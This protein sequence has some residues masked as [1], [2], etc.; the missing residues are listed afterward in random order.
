MTRRDIMTSESTL[1]GLAAFGWLM[2]IAACVAEFRMLRADMKE[3]RR[4]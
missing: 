1:I 3:S 4:G 2:F